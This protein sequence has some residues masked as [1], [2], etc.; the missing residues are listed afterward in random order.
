[1]QGFCGE[2]HSVKSWC[3]HRYCESCFNDYI[4]QRVIDRTPLECAFC[5]TSL[6]N[7]VIFVSYKNK[8]LPNLWLKLK[9]SILPFN[10]IIIC[11]NN[12]K[13]N[14]FLNSLIVFL[15]PN[16][17][18]SFITPNDLIVEYGDNSL[19]ICDNTNTTTSNHNIIKHFNSNILSLCI[20]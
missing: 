15:N 16:K 8:Y 9:N 13:I 1:M 2:S 6:L 20:G 12:K 7:K 5:R 3:I 10:E 4:N 17:I 19:I 14:N 18:I 11:G